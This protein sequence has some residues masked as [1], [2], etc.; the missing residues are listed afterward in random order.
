MTRP[1]RVAILAHS[2]NPR[3]G[4]A[5]ALSLAEALGDLG[6]EAVVHAPDAKGTGFF[7]PARCRTLGV[8]ASPCG[9][10]LRDLV[11]TRIADYVRHF[12]APAHRRFDVF[13]AHDGISA[14]ALADLRARGL[15][16][17]FAYTVHHV[18]RFADPVVETRQNRAVAAADRHF[19][20]SRL[21]HDKLRR[22]YG[23]SAAVVGNGVDRGV[24]D[25]ASDGRETTLRERLGLGM[26][27]VFLAVGGVEAR[28]NTVRILQAFAAVAAAEPDAGLVIAGG[29]SLLDHGAYRTR[30]DAEL[31]RLGGAG[32][33]VVQLGPVDQADM[34][35]LYRLAAAL[36]FPSLVEGFG[37]AAI[38]AL[39][40]GAPAI[41]SRIAPFTEHFRAGDVLWCDPDDPSSIAGA[42]RDVLRRDVRTR[43]AARREA[44]LAPHSWDRVA[45]AHLS[46]YAELCETAYA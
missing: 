4:V 21:W 40:C 9:P 3:G 25:S 24:F 14:N 23:I 34:P 43:L 16:D 41:V 18:D 7:R 13:H 20:V 42:M 37:L 45:R 11:E 31:T 17:G 28:K 8:A 2:T 36:V 29:A 38:E 44:T 19:A 27:P 35:A 1:L 26:G 5:H 12:E 46:A 32:Q 15:I 22:E 30:F 39:A 6:H 33:R 10:T